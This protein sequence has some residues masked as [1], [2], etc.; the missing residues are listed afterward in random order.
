MSGAVLTAAFLVAGA[1]PWLVLAAAV[2]AWS[3]LL[4]AT[5]AIAGAGLPVARRRGRRAPS[6]DETAFLNAV[7][8]ELRAGASLPFALAAAS[9]LV[10]DEPL[11]EAAAR[12]CRGAP[13]RPVVRRLG[14][15]L[16]VGGRFA[17]FTVAVVAESGGAAARTFDRL[18]ARSARMLEVRRE[19]RAATAQVRF[20]ALVVGGAPLAVL[21]TLAATGGAADLWAGGPAGRGALLV[22]AG[23]VAA[24]LV[25][26]AVMV[27]RF[28]P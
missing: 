19:M 23:L 14:E 27:R 25:A 10:P 1:G 8:A 18:A 17:S 9:S 4:S 6:V 3:P 2:W 26:V 21:A 15:V 28:D 13:L 5:V 11:R 22:G 7:A 12:A 24:G 20:S 16:P